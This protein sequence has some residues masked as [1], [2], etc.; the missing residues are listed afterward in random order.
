MSTSSLPSRM[1]SVVFTLMLLPAVAPLAQALPRR[2]D[3][4]RPP[5]SVCATALARAEAL[6]S[7]STRSEIDRSFARLSGCKPEYGRGVAAA[8]TAVRATRDTTLAAAAF[9][10]AIRQKDAAIARAAA[11]I[12]RDPS[13]SEVVRT[14]SLMA[15]YSHL[16][17]RQTSL[18]AF[19][20]QPR[21]AAGCIYPISTG[22]VKPV[23]LTPLPPD[24]P[25]QARDAAWAVQRDPAASAALIGASYCV[26][27]AWR[28]VRNLPSQSNWLF[29]PGAITAEYLCGTKFRVLNADPAPVTLQWH[30]GSSALN[31]MFLAAAPAGAQHSSEVVTVPRPG[32]LTLY[33]DGELVSTTENRGTACG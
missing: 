7:S 6:S 15:L 11:E 28:K 12:A 22:N 30:V 10:S 8:M 9:I 18:A 16:V 19:S 17:E 33:F 1:A 2:L 24:A 20:D 31:P 5:D 14:L 4:P 13:A 23:E 26:L 25:E 3:I 21:G 29:T 27:E 32:P